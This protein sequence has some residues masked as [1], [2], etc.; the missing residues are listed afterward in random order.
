MGLDDLTGTESLGIKWH[1]YVPQFQP[2]ALTLR[3]FVM[4]QTTLTPAETCMIPFSD[5][6]GSTMDQELPAGSQRDPRQPRQPRFWTG[7]APRPVM[8]L[9]TF[10]V[11][12]AD[13]FS[14]QG[15]P[16]PEGGP[17][18]VVG[19]TADL[20]HLPWGV[21]KRPGRAFW[22]RVADILSV[23]YLGEEK[24]IWYLNG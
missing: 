22:V 3:S 7:S 8:G 9:A 4:A 21:H 18:K 6:G 2:P 19:S 14:D 24:K 13:S 16:F 1:H 23:P 15:L 5:P 17:Y 12:P 20:D 10:W 11:V